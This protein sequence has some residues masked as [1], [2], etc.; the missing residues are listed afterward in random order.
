M[1]WRN[2]L[3]K[4]L[5]EQGFTEDNFPPYIKEY[6]PFY[7]GF[8]YKPE[9]CR[10][11]RYQTGCGLTIP[12]SEVIG[13][14]NYLGYD[15]SYENF[16]PAILCPYDKENCENNHPVLRKKSPNGF[17][18]CRCHPVEVEISQR[19]TLQEALAK[20]DVRQKK[21]LKEYTRKNDGSYCLHH[22][23]FDK[24]AGNWVLDYKPLKCSQCKKTDYCT[25]L[26]IPLSPKKGNV[27]YDCRMVYTNEDSIFHNIPVVTIYKKIPVLKEPIS[28]TICELIA[29]LCGEKIIQEEFFHP[30]NMPK[31]D[32][33]QNFN[34]R[35]LVNGAEE[36]GL[37]GSEL[38]DGA[39][40]LYYADMQ[41]ESQIKKDKQR[42]EAFSKNVKIMEK[43]VLEHGFEELRE[44]EKRRIRKFLDEK[45][46]NE[47]LKKREPKNQDTLFNPL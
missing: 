44:Y 12:G 14:M 17:C 24:Q 5:L 27:Y 41:L 29:E 47:L 15:W 43:Y 1:E 22:M 26:K 33:V 23:K 42:S 38:E 9:Y 46:I 34:V 16:N 7:G 13:T 45:Q 11:L 3:T 8:I 30:Y 36:A 6:Q 18:F 31:M 20:E 40:I 37:D 32:L 39:S 2:E 4:L 35:A 19:E 10:T 21:L 28:I 25:L